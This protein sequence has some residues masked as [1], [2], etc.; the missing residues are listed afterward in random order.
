MMCICI[1]CVY[2]STFTLFVYIFCRAPRLLSY[3][4]LYGAEHD[5]RYTSEPQLH[6]QAPKYSKIM[7]ARPVC[8]GQATSIREI[9]AM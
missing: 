6:A 2:E 3:H 7:P 1:V 9:P 5:P 8:V 4:P